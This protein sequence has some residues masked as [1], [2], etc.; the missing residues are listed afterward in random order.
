MLTTTSHQR[1]INQ[2]HKRDSMS[3]PL[4]G[5]ESNNG[6]IT[7]VREAAEKLEF[8]PTA[9]GECKMVLPLGCLKS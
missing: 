2:N 3:H 4:G 9:R 8:S 1:N 5:L 6:Q 7:S